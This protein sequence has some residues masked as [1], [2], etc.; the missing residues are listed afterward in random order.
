M[1]KFAHLQNLHVAAN[2]TAEYIFYGIDGHPVLT[3]HP[4]TEANKPYFNAVLKRTSRTAKM[5]RAGGEMNAEQLKEA[6]VED[7]ELY[8][9]HVVRGWSK[10]VD[11]EL[12]EV[13]FSVEDCEEFL[14]AIP[15]YMFDDFRTFCGNPR[16]FVEHGDPEETAGNSQQG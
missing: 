8:P 15:D 10:V 11:S 6:R 2:A 14:T 4:A 7:R 12:N 9:K 5:L 16:N 1:S 3:V 13:P